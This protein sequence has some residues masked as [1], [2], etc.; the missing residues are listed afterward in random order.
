VKTKVNS[1]SAGAF[2]IDQKGNRRSRLPLKLAVGPGN[3]AIAPL[4]CSLSQMTGNLHFLAVVLPEIK[5]KN[6]WKFF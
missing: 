1:R 2:D 6:V 4:L 5:S 3:V